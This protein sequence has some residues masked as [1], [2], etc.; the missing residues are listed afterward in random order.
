MTLKEKIL[1]L[2]GYEYIRRCGDQKQNVRNAYEAALELA[3]MPMDHRE[4]AY[5]M[6]DRVGKFC[7]VYEATLN[8]IACDIYDALDLAGGAAGSASIKDIDYV[9]PEDALK[10]HQISLAQHQAK[11]FQWDVQAIMGVPVDG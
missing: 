2:D 1:A 6:F 4:P 8:E 10:L 7:W 11:E 9:S 5:K 3:D